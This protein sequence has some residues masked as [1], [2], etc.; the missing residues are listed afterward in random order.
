MFTKKELQN[1]IRYLMVPLKGTETITM[2]LICKVGSRYEKKHLAGSSHYIEHLMFKGTK[3][4]PNTLA[5]SKELDSIGS[6]YNAFTGKEYTAYYIKSNKKHFEKSCSIIFDMINNSLFD[7]KEMEREKRVIIE[8]IN[9]YNDNPLFH[10]DELFERIVY[11]GNTLGDDIAGTKEV[12]A[13]YKREDV[14]KFKDEA[15]SSNNITVV[16]SGNIDESSEKVFKEYFDNYSNVIDNTIDFAKFVDNQK[17]PRVT[18]EYK[19]TE[20]VQMELGFPAFSYSHKD[21]PALRLLSI[22]LG[23]NMSSRLFIQIRERKGLCYAIRSSTDMYQDTGVLKIKAGI[24]KGR[25][26]RAIHYIKDEL[27]KIMN[28]SVSDSE[29]KRAKDYL[30]GKFSISLED[31]FELGVWYGIQD[32]FLDKIKTPKE[33]LDDY[34]KVTPEDIKRVAN[35]IMDMNKFNLAVLGPFKDKEKFMK[36]ITK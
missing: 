33:K 9:M 8:E 2:M 12:V 13:N 19:E 31:S 24:D 3:K 26:Y 27:E 14:L 17:D 15:Y 1:K 35:N 20:Q 21:L 11:Q 36:V 22:I 18:I 7:E 32:L 28:Q 29:L 16:L 25:I 30:E 10:I 34:F 23:G 5:L 6:E 4:C